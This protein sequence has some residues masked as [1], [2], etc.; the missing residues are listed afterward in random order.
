MAKLP[1][2]LYVTAQKKI[3]DEAPLGF[4][5][6]YEP[7]KASFQKKRLTQEEWAF[8]NYYVQDMQLET[9]GTEVWITGWKW[10]LG[11]STT[12]GSYIKETVHELLEN[13]PQIWT[14][15]PLEGFKIVKSVS[16]YSTSN[17]LWR[18]LDPRNIEFEISTN[19]MEQIIADTVIKNGLIDAKCAWMG[20]KNLVVVP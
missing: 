11:P 5:N 16:R 15:T 6:A 18:I 19:C 14:N 3:D 12:R 20:N 2:E 9:R 17:K 10:Q 1:K 7:N 8:N 13:P 4:L